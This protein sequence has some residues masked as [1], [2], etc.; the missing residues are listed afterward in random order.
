MSFKIFK[1]FLHPFVALVLSILNI[2]A[3]SFAVNGLFML[4]D[5]I[6]ID[7][8]I[9]PSRFNPLYVFLFEILL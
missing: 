1:A 5:A 8:A 7:A 3:I 6:Y 2:R 9:I 4:L